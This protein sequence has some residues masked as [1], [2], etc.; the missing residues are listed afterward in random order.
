MCW[1]RARR[2]AT[3]FTRENGANLRAENQL[4]EAT[5]LELTNSQSDV[6]RW[7]FGF[8]VREIDIAAGETVQMDTLLNTRGADTLVREAPDA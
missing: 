5:L 3:W 8:R 7:G 1:E 6:T 4:R 2:R